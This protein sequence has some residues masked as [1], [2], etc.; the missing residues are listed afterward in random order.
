MNRTIPILL[1]VLLCAGC[2]GGDRLSAG[3]CQ[4]LGDKLI[5][6]RNEGKTEAEVAQAR[7]EDARSDSEVALDCAA[8]RSFDLTDYKCFMAAPNRE[9]S[10]KCW[11]PVTKR[12]MDNFDKT[13]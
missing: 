1:M 11:A 12:A 13:R 3:E 4:I 2:G 5:A 9:Q 8:G 10:L 6:F 7:K